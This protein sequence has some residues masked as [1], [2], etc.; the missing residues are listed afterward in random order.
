MVRVA[1]RE[2]AGAGPADGAR[3]RTDGTGGTP[4][5]GAAA[6]GLRAWRLVG[7]LVMAVV[8]V[9]S[10]SQALG[11]LVEQHSV[12][13]KTYALAARELLLDGAGADVRIEPGLPGQVLVRTSLDWTLRKPLVAMLWEGDTL[14]VTVRCDRM[15]DLG[16]LGCG[17]RLDIRV[18][19]ATAVTGRSTS[20]STEVRGLTG[21][22]RLLSAS[23]AVVL[24]GLGG[25]VSAMSTSGAVWGTALTS[26]RVEVVTRSGEA[27]LSFARPPD[28]VTA[29]TTSGELSLTV[30]SASRY[31][32][33]GR[34]NSGGR[35]I[36]PVLEE[37]GA[38]RSI[39][40]STTSGSVSISS[41]DG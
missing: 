2:K 16:G 9:L 35:S 7:G 31:R 41:S 24:S 10:G 34:S 37:P 17:V 3:E 15:L 28:A 11:V 5:P 36:D 6:P 27:R 12:R 23:G 33:T 22:V 18:P 20:G 30:P 13:D 19:A 4:R 40:V 1:G 26:A 39:D 38:P 32:I 21:D 8:L 14:K 29:S 25:R